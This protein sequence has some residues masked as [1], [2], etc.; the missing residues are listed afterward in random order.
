MFSNRVISPLHVS[1]SHISVYL[2]LFLLA[3]TQ[4]GLNMQAND[5]QIGPQKILEPEMFTSSVMK[6]CNQLKKLDNGFNQFFFSYNAT[7]ITF[8]CFECRFYKCHNAVARC[9][10]TILMPTVK[11]MNV[12]FVFFLFNLD[13]AFPLGF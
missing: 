1:L 6:E 3:T 12:C 7:I 11:Y 13:S 2:M 5:P 9:N 4:M 10:K 8:K